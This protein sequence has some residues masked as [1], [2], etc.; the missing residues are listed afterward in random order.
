MFTIRVYGI[1]IEQS[2]LLVTDEFRLGI[3]M[4]KFPGGGLEYGEGTLDCLK[5]EWKEET[6]LEIEVISHYYTTDFFQPAFKLPESRQVI[7]IYYRVRAIH[8]YQLTTT[9]KVFDFPEIT[10]GAQTFRWIPLSEVD[11]A[12][13][14]LPVDKVVVQKLLEDYHQGLLIVKEV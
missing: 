11:T 1:L 9:K 4:T 14:T 2:R 10:D 7:N 5:R 6:G 12:L 8:P 3:F 13:F